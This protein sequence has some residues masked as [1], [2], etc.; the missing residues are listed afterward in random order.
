MKY[1]K[2]THSIDRKIIG[3]FP[4]SEECFVGD[5]QKD[6]I[7]WEGPIDF[8]FK[9]PE[10]ILEKKSK[11][12]SYVRVVAISVRFLVVDNEFLNFLKN[13]NIGNYQKW[14]IKTWQNEE[15][16][17]KYNLFILNDTKQSE[18]IDFEKSDF[19][20]GKLGDWKDRSTRR[21]ISIKNYDEYIYKKEKLGKESLMLLHDKV[22][23]D[24]KGVNVDM[25]RIVNAPLGGYYVSERLKNAIEE[26][27]FTGMEFKEVGELDKVEVI[28]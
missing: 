7:P 26:N 4:Q 5:I 1:Y 28:Y 2:L 24:L 25:F 9:L 22:T 12:T 14:K 23:L 8:D 18:Y 3:V 10:P 13:Y 20:I 16:I 19:L 11:Q 6:F 17:K 21:P 27:G 15:L